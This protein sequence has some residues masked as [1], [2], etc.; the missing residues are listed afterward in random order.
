MTHNRVHINLSA[1]LEFFI[2]SSSAGER[3]KIPFLKMG[4]M[5][6]TDENLSTWRRA[7]SS[8]TFILSFRCVSCDGSVAFPK[9]IL[10]ECDQCFPPHSGT[11][12]FHY[13]C[14]QLPTS[15]S[16]F[17]YP[18]YLS[19]NKTNETKVSFFFTFCWPYIS[20][21]LSQYL[22]NFMQKICFTISFISC[23]NMFRA[24]VL[25]IRRSKFHETATY[26][27]DDTRGC[28]MQFWPPDEKQMCSKHVEAWN[29][30]Y[31]KTNFVHQVG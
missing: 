26:R 16:S 3:E 6:L 13:G 5:M 28:V 4:G 17:S 23:L 24:H 7:Y 19:S 8:S 29:K 9:R 25:I 14:I 15:S 30:T 20:V 31:C 27:C 1:I 21:Y 2:H 12:S 18:F 10:P 11:F 22:T